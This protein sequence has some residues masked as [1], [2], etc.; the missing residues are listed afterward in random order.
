MFWRGS[1]V[2]ITWA[3]KSLWVVTGAILGA[4]VVIGSTVLAERESVNIQ[5]EQIQKSTSLPLQ[6]LRTFV[7]VFERISR[8]FVEPVED[9]KL[10]E[11]A[12][13][14][15]LSALD[16]HSA[17]LPPKEFALME[18]RTK[19]EFG[20]LGME[21][22]MEDGFIKV[23]SPIDDTPAQAAGIQAGDLIIKLDDERVKGKSLSEAVKMMRGKPGTNI[24][25]TIVRKG[26][27]VPL[28][29]ELTRAIIKVQ[30]VRAR[31]LTDG[32]GY[33]RISQFQLRTGPDLI[34]A[35]QQ[36]EKDNKEPLKG[37]VLDL[38]NN[39]GGVLRAAVQV[40]D[41]FLDGG[42]IVYTRGRVENVQ[43]RFEAEKGDLL[44]GKP[45]IIL[46]NE[47]SASASEIVAGA[48][49]DHNRA[50]IIGRNSFGK[51]SVQT[52]IPLNSG[53]AIKLTTARY[54][55]PSGYSIQT[56]GIQPDIKIDRVRVEKI[57]ATF[58][59][60][61]EKDLVGHLDHKDDKEQTVK[62]LSEEDKIAEIEALLAKDY[63]LSKA[64]R[65]LKGMSFMHQKTIN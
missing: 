1:R 16:P 15:M 54:F 48:L 50:L 43:M 38:R 34:K 26:E 47:G 45:V 36:I 24:S 21:V 14:G 20:G 55:T 7:E 52:L 12:I 62:E 17:F 22:G 4:S 31:M 33:V 44:N 5:E 10:L 13:S 25:L 39:P 63:E 51:G 35:I 27:T 37:L 28:I 29:I 23:I 30:S 46:I 59:S 61:K 41:V 64:L 8:D 57:E 40:S 49:Q 58:A 60:V 19:G 53:G 56:E 3:K 6:E 65:I 18:E 11:G 2:K 32:M 42:L 9:E